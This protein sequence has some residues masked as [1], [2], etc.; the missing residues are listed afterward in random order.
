MTQRLRLNADRNIGLS[1]TLSADGTS[2]A[3][4]DGIS[5]SA[6]APARVRQR[7]VDDQELDRL[8]AAAVAEER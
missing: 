5:P 2:L 4:S 8:L 1:A 6:S 3:A 7:S